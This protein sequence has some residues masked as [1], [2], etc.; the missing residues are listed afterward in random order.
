MNE[1]KRG[2]KKGGAPQGEE[3]EKLTKLQKA[4]AHWL[5]NSGLLIIIF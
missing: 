2:K 1:K 5:R 4:V 3:A